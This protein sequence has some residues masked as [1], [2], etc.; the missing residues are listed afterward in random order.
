MGRQ[1][2]PVPY[3]ALDLAETPEQRLA[4]LALYELGHT[5]R[6]R[7]TPRS[8]RSLARAHGMSEPTMRRLLERLERHGLIIRHQVTTGKRREGLSIEVLDPQKD[9]T[10]DRTHDRTHERRTTGRTTC[11][12]TG[13]TTGRTSDARRDARPDAPT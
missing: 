7:P 9:V 10:H 2:V 5:R 8:C 4:V 12:T 1:F 3:D 11:R 13:R 6:W